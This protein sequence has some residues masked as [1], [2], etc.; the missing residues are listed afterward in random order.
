MLGIQGLPTKSLAGWQSHRWLEP[1]KEEAQGLITWY[2]PQV[3]AVGEHP[4]VWPSLCHQYS[5]LALGF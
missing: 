5:L 2:L 3:T 4:K 1:N